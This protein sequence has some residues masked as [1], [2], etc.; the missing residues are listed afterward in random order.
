M[1]SASLA[2][3]GQCRSL[4]QHSVVGPVPVTDYAGNIVGYDW[5]GHNAY[6]RFDR[7]T[8]R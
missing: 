7:V 3:E 6:L 4:W 8:D 2:G 1:P 5:K